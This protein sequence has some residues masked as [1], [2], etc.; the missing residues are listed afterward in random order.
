MS[1]FKNNV[2]NQR[3][4]IVYERL[5][6]DKKI[7]G[8]SDLAK[9]LGTYNHVINDVLNSRRNITVDQINDLCRMFGVNTN[10]IFGFSDEIYEGE[11]GEATASLRAWGNT[12]YVGRHNITLV[13]QRALAGYALNPGDFGMMA[14]LQKFSLPNMEGELVAFEISGDSMLPNITNGDLVICELLERNEPLRDNVVYVIVTDVV[15]AKRVQ[16]IRNSKGIVNQLK[17]I[18]DNDATYKPYVVDLEE[19]R[20]ILR[21]K[22]RVTAY[23]IG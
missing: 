8:K 14:E 16:Q 23:G 7:K 17:L 9:K 1:D 6:R 15:V 21:V 5:D 20:Q 19:V 12:G 2:V 11:G 13:P 22:S 10:F 3:F 4:R 18:S